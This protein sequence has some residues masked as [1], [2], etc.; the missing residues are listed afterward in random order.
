MIARPV[1]LKR[2]IVLKLDNLEVPGHAVPREFIDQMSPYRITE[3]YLT[4]T[5]IGPVM[6]KLTRV[7]IAEGKLVFTRI[8]GEIPAD[9][10]GKEQVDSASSRFFMILGIVACVFLLFAGLVVFL[11]LRAKARRS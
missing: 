2:E 11:G 1:L 8:P 10:I 9:V 7:G 4:D 3:R 5:T 6:A